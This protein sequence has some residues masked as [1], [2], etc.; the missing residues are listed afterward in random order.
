VQPIKPDS[1]HDIL[2]NFVRGS[3]GYRTE[4]HD[5]GKGV[6]T[7]GC[8]TALL[9]KGK[10]GWT[11]LEKLDERLQEAGVQL[12]SSRYAVDKNKLNQIAIA[13]GKQKVEEA[14]KL[15]RE[16][17]FSIEVNREQARKLYD[18]GMER[19]HL[20]I[21]KNKLDRS[22]RRTNKKARTY[23]QLAGSRELIALADISYSG[24][25]RLTDELIGYV[26]AGER[27]KTFYHIAYK[28]R[29]KDKLDKYSG[30]VTRSYNEAYMFGY[31]AGNKPSEA[32]IRALEEVYAK[33]K[34]G[35]DNYDKKWGE[36]LKKEVK[37]WVPF[38][39][40]IRL[41][42]QGKVVAW[43]PPDPHNKGT[44][45]PGVSAEQ[46]AVMTEFY[47]PGARPQQPGISAY[48]IA[49]LRYSGGGSDAPLKNFCD[50]YQII[51]RRF[52][53]N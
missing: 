35:I 51:K 2:F 17:N 29:E 31:A 24:P 37:G 36:K 11:V 8:G 38:S 7:I 44:K 6:P 50:P 3:E 41:A 18:I 49:M 12:D 53:G 26:V 9:I 40:L 43:A 45:R 34:Q 52:D 4:V 15:I 23:E 47:I 10:E 19:D 28:T 25:I 33:N 32:D 39:E 27:Q 14:Q 16:Y 1:F 42:K 46:I 22:D 5:D 30:Y 13:L 20:S 21:V 48:E